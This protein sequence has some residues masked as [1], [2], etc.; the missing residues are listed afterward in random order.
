MSYLW[1]AEEVIILLTED[2]MRR[3]SA[4]R[5]ALRQALRAE[6]QLKTSGKAVN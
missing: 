1:P 4:I 2:D 5:A 6:L 3:T